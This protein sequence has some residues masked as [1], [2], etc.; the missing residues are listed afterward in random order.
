M[1]DNNELVEKIILKS[2]NKI[3][4]SEFL[5]EDTTMKKVNK[6]PKMVATIIV[7]IG[8]MSGLVY[9][10]ANIYDKIWKEPVWIKK[11]IYSRNEKIW[12]LFCYYSYN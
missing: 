11:R 7:T 8:I 3:A 4:V 1:N 6:I 12:R 9:A 5:E 10:T 2:K